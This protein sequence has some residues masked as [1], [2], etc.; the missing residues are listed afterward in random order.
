MDY[1][2]VGSNRTM[3]RRLILFLSL[4]LALTLAACGR[5]AA[6]PAT[7]GAV[8]APT[9][10]P[11][12]YTLGRV[13]PASLPQICRCTLRFDH[14]ASEQGLSQSSVQVIFQDSLGFLWFGT[15]DGL[16]RYDGHTFNTYKPDPDVAS[17]LSDR[18]I[19]SIVED[20]NGYLWIA[21]RQ[22]GLNR[23]DLR[24]EQFTHFLHDEADPTTVS[25]NY[26]SVLY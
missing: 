12:P 1:T 7:P 19:N 3:E 22:G 23:F 4:L 14:I 25:D 20:Q 10:R 11:F 5:R 8:S 17:S 15:E 2:V 18:W 13:S 26:I 16:N 24:T 6:A 21:T 9:S